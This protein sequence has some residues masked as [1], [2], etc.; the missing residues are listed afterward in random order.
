VNRVGVVAGVTDE[1]GRERETQKQE[2]KRVFFLKKKCIY[3][4][5][6]VV[7]LLKA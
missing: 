7:F 1:R 4:Q 5:S 3:K 6:S 2:W